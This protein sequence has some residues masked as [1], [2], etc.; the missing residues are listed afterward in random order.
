MAVP[1]KRQSKTRTAK[2][3]ANWKVTAP[4][5]NT[6]PNCHEPKLPHRVCPSCGVYNNRQVLEVEEQ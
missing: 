3:R 4:K 1:K 2:R 5:V 6:C